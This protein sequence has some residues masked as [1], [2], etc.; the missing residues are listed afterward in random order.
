MNI[1]SSTRGAYSS[2]DNAV[3]VDVKTLAPEEQGE[4]FI[5]ANVGNEATIGQ[6]MVVAANLVYTAKNGAQGDAIAYITHRVVAAG[7]ING[8]GA[9]IFGAGSF[10]PTTLLGWLVLIIL[11]LA[12]VLL[13][14]HLYGRYSKDK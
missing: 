2:A 10:L 6:L 1:E 7:S 9:S 4:A 11:V 14:N 12:L 3:V 13:G 5:F 8:L